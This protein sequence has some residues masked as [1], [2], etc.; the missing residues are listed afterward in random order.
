MNPDNAW[1]LWISE[2][3]REVKKGVKSYKICVTNKKD[4]VKNKQPNLSRFTKKMVFCLDHPGKKD[5]KS[6]S[7]KR[8]KKLKARIGLIILF[9]LL[10]SKFKIETSLSLIA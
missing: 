7:L 3:W 5:F 6:V 4:F 8:R 2:S 1:A 10:N 9:N